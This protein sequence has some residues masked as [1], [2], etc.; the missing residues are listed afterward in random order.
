MAGMP[1]VAATS[2]GDMEDAPG[3]GVGDVG[4]SGVGVV[5]A[6]ALGEVV[7]STAEEF[8][9]SPGGPVPGSLLGVVVDSGGP[10]SK[11]P[12]DSPVNT[13]LVVVRLPTP[14]GGVNGGRVGVGLG[15][16]SSEGVGEGS[17]GG[18]GS[19]GMGSDGM[20]SGGMG[21]GGASA[22]CG[23]GNA[24]DTGIQPKARSMALTDIN[25]RR[26]FFGRAH[27]VCY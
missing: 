6:S 7:G 17:M 18:M 1:V 4:F 2:V 10:P 16:D 9:W 27:A 23:A 22:S 24:H 8:T 19:E 11:R 15:E 5:V 20:G 13:C 3:L 25:M 12:V 21:G 14:G 26:N